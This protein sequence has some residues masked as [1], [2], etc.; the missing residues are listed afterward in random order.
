MNILSNCSLSIK[1]YIIYE[2]KEI[3]V[4]NKPEGLLT[5]PDGFQPNLPN[6]RDLLISKFGSIWVVHRLDKQTSGV[7][8]FAKDKNTHKMLSI[9]FQNREIKKSYL[10][11]VHGFPLWNQKIIDYPIQINGDRRH[12]TIVDMQF[13]KKALS[14]V[15]F[16]RKFNT[17]SY[18][19]IYPESGY[20]HQ[21]R[22]HLAAIGHPIIGDYLYNLLRFK[23]NEN[24]ISIPANQDG[25]FLH[26]ASISFYL[27][28]NRQE[29]ITAPLPEKF[30]RYLPSL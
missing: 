17:Y 23:D 7:L 28:G 10:A 2:D 14:K 30:Q 5:I 22:C 18:V 29:I 25:M 3:I 21:I 11:L 6:L 1:K 26:A 24:Q 8:I 13:G 9:Q 27:S 15:E 12:R 19:Q 4:I 16:I 20:S